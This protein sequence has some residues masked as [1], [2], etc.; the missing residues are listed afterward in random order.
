M[1]RRRTA[2][3][4]RQPDSA[5]TCHGTWSP[6]GM[7]VSIHGKTGSSFAGGVTAAVSRHG[8]AW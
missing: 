3:W 5:R 8:L 4:S 7:L 1:C 2:A 6:G